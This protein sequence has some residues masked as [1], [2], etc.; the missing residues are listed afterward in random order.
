[1]NKSCLIVLMALSVAFVFAELGPVNAMGDNYF[2]GKLGCYAKGDTLAYVSAKQSENNNLYYHIFF[3]ISYDGGQTWQSSVVDSSLY[4]PTEPT[5]FYSPEE[6]IVSWNI[7]ED[8]ISR[9]AQSFNSGISWTTSQNWN[10]F[11][12]NPYIEKYNGVLRQFSLK[13][14][15]PQWDQEQYLMPDAPE[16]FKP[17]HKYFKESVSPNQTNLYYY[18]LDDVQGVVRCNDDLFIKQVGGGTNNGWPTF[19]EPVIISGDVSTNL[20]AYPLASIFPGGL[21]KNAPPLEFSNFSFARQNYTFVG[22]SEYDPNRILLVN[23]NGANYTSFIGQIMLPRTVTTDVW[24]N[25]PVGIAGPP[26][27]TNTFTVSDTIWTPG[28]SGLCSNRGLFVNSKLWI[29]GTFSG[30][31]VWCAADT[32]MIIGEILL[33]G[34]VPGVSPA[35]NPNDSVKL[36][37]ERS[38]LLKYG[39]VDPVTRQRI[40]PN[41]FSDNVS[42]NYY[43]DIY[44]LWED[45]VNPYRKDG[46]FSFEYQHPHPAM[47]DMVINDTLYTWIDL[48]RYHYPQTSANPWLQ[49]LDLPWYNPLWPEAHPYLE[50]GIIQIWGSIN[51]IRRGFMHRSYYDVEYPSGGIWNPDIDYCGGSSYV[52]YNDPATGIPLFTQNYHFAVGSGVGYQTIYQADNRFGWG[53]EDP[54][55]PVFYP[56]KLGISI[57]DFVNNEITD[58]DWVPQ[59]KPVHSKCFTRKSEQAFYAANDVLACRKGDSTSIENLTALTKDQGDIY[60]LHIL[61]D[62]S[63]LVHQE[64][65]TNGNRELKITAFSGDSHTVTTSV[66]LPVFSGM[67]DV[68]VREDGNIILAT[69]EANRTINLQRLNADGTLTALETWQLNFLDPQTQIHPK[70]KIC[71][72]PRHQNALEVTFMLFTEGENNELDYYQLY[73]AYA[74][75]PLANEDPSVPAALPVLFYAYP[76]PV[77]SNLKLQLQVPDYNTHKIEIYNLKGQKVATLNGTSAKNEIVEYNWNGCDA[78]GKNVAA[79]VYLVRLTVNGKVLPSKRICKY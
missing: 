41:C 74:S 72:Q 12:S 21:I 70:S 3:Q 37:S 47:P 68:A 7:R 55:H 77:H 36:V 78:K 10:S 62:N 17:V 57:E 20:P 42:G 6:I 63:L 67:N 59:Y 26:L 44:A 13:V 4:H 71:L 38:V 66:S 18:G 53:F 54:S 45:P 46:V 76:N 33:S 48:H 52:I 11:E 43:T 34:T 15:Y 69:L 28:P 49:N 2:A 25:Y 1:M 23:V 51:Q 50:R 5:L 29:K 73:R 75:V 79:G 58:I 35:N 24:T 65:V 61:A 40:H 22:P 27:F 56:W 19:H 39:Y 30:H 32:I 14:P 64:K 16:R 9:Y 8:H 31:Q 60:G